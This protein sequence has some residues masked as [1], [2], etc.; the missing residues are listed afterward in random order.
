MNLPR[1]SPGVL[2][3][4]DGMGDSAAVRVAAGFADRRAVPLTVVHVVEASLL[5]RAP[6]PDPL[7]VAVDVARTMY[8]HL[9]VRALG[10]TGPVRTVLAELAEEHEL[11]VLGSRGHGSLRDAAFGSH[12]LDLAAHAPC[13][14]V[15]VRP[16][17]ARP[18]SGAPVVV[19]LGG[20]ASDAPVLE[21]AFAEAADR[22][23]S[24][25][26]VRSVDRLRP[27]GRLVFAALAPASAADPEEEVRAE[28][29]PW[30]DRYPGVRVQVEICHGR[31]ATS[32]LDTT[33]GAAL[34][35]IGCRGRGARTALALGSVSQAVLHHVHTP[36]A[37]VTACP[38]DP[39]YGPRP[40]GP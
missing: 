33:R 40:P 16:G 39:R 23:V 25:I 17:P 18:R 7:P 2:V 19:A 22:G 30:S 5:P 6:G 31:P 15:V 36:I 13:P 10:R 4:V 21:F 35:V 29:R 28:L 37:I 3:A 9:D 1:A 20:S 34:L 32:I 24:L 26:A 8:P 27:A 38:D 11:I 12:G 14:V